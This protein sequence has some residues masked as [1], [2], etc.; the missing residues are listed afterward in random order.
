MLIQTF[1]NV[2]ALSPVVEEPSSAGN[3]K[4]HARATSTAHDDIA[5][6][7]APS[8]RQRISIDSTSAEAPNTG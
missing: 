6:S 4:D 7:A 1:D 3:D 8:K 5:G 2:A